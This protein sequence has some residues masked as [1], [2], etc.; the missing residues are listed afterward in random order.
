MTLKFR[1]THAL[2][3]ASAA[4]A[5]LTGCTDKMGQQQQKAAA[6]PQAVQ[7]VVEQVELSDAV[8]RTEAPGRATAYQVAEVRPQVSGILQKRLFEEGAVVKQGQSLYRIDPAIYKAQLASAKAA[9]LQANANLA[10]AKADAKRSAELVKVNA[11]SRSADDQAQAAWKVAEANVAAAKAAL[12]TAQIN[13]NYTEVRSPITGRVSLS[14]VTPGAL[15]TANQTSRLTVVQQLDPIYVDVTQSYSELSRLRE[16]AAQ[17]TLKVN[18]DGSADVQLVLDGNKVY[19]HLGR[20][21][22]KD[23]LVDEGTGTVRVRAVFDNPEGDLMPGMFV[24]A[25][26]IDGVRENVIKVDQRA[27]MRRTTGDP[28]VYIV[29]AENK[30]ESRDIKVS[31]TEGGK[32]IVE[33]GLKAGDKVIVEGIQRVRPGALVQ[34]AP[35]AGAAAPAAAKAAAFAGK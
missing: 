30:V 29:N 35:A 26:L 22:F 4:A 21:T 24:R 18:A 20:L 13:L 14:E 2:L 7:V 33:S 25:R 10:S 1:A 5:A 28:Y 9:L 3:I 31:G 11:V 16:Q 19:K 27:T 23:A 17:G 32:W 6:A 34:I 8:I 12:E 15:V